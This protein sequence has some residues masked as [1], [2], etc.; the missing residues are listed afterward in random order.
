MTLEGQ[1]REMEAELQVLERQ[2]RFDDQAGLRINEIEEQREALLELL[3]EKQSELDR[4]TIRAPVAGVILPVVD[5]PDRD[6][7]DG[8]LPDWTGSILSPRNL[9]AHLTPSDRICQIGVLPETDGEPSLDPLR[10]VELVAEVIVDQVDVQLVRAAQAERELQAESGIPVKLM[11]DS[12][13]GRTFDS[14]IEQIALAEMTETPLGLSTHAGG[15]VDSVADPETGMP[16]PLSTSY[17][18]IAALP[19][20]Q[21]TIQLGMRGKAKLYTGW[22]PLRHR[23]FRFV[24]RTFHFEF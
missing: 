14:H 1:L 13:P 22:Q 12:L 9:N 11:L 2:Q 23:V 6:T 8:Q 4:L 20:T 18:A 7:G 5:K 17:P 10:R 19:D 24:S 16:K 15:D 21:G 3:A